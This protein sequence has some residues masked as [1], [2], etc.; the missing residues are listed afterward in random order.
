MVCIEGRPRPRRWGGPLCV[1]AAGRSISARSGEKDRTESQENT[2]TSIT[3]T[4]HQRKKAL[5]PR[6]QK[7]P[8]PGPKAE[9]KEAASTKKRPALLQP[10]QTETGPVARETAIPRTTKKNPSLCVQ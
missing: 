3:H 7:P 8:R 5:V 10:Q 2:H 1:L 4:P 9:K 6:N